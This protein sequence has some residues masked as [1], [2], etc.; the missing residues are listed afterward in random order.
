MEDS[1][2]YVC[3]ARNDAGTAFGQIRL[4]VAGNLAC[5]KS[6]ANDMV[7]VLIPSFGNCLFEHH[8]VL[9]HLL[10]NI[11]LSSFCIPKVLKSA[12]KILKIG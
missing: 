5:L 2:V 12:A 10:T 7:T 8:Y 1:G 11:I 3:I 9:K 4:T 6:G